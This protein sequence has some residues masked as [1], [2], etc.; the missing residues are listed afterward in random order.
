M[1]VLVVSTAGVGHIYPLV[2]IARALRAARHE[3]LWAVP[4][5]AV[6]TVESS[7]MRA[8]PAGMH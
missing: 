5:D 7:G 8:Q 3:L 2:P 6:G 1:R 4:P